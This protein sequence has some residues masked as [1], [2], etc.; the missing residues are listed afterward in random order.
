MDRCLLAFNQTRY[1]S[2]KKRGVRKKIKPN[3]QG[4]VMSN[5]QDEKVQHVA[6]E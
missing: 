6:F 3:G 2:K 1:T 5:A 4:K